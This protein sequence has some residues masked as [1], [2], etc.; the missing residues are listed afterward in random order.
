MHSWPIF[1]GTQCFSQAD[2]ALRSARNLP[3]WSGEAGFS[4]QSLNGIMI[5][6]TE[7]I[8]GVYKSTF[9]IGFFPNGLSQFFNELD[10]LKVEV[11]EDSICRVMILNQGGK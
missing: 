2:R 7:N 1:T 8:V 9:L 10:Q 5:M 3:S 11:K 4:Q 6:E